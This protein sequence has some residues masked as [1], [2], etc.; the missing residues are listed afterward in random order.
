MANPLFERF[1]NLGIPGPL[2]NMTNFMNSFNQ[3][4]NGLG[5]NPQQQN[6][7]AQQQVQ[8]MLNSGQISQDQLN[9]AMNFAQM[10]Q[11]MMHK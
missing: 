9:Q 10:L 7:F 6:S 1:G 5:G 8:Q 11:G 2:Q 3:F 4:R